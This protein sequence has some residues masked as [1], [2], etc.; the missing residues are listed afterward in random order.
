MQ[1]FLSKINLDFENL[2]RYASFYPDNFSKKE[3]LYLDNKFTVL[4][5]NKNIKNVN[6]FLKREDRSITNS[7]KNRGVSYQLSCAKKEG[8]DKFVLSTSGNAGITACQFLEKHGG[9]IIVVT[10][11][12][13]PKRKI[14]KLK[15]L[16]KNLILS[17]NPPHTANYI[18]KKYYYKNIR[19]S[20]DKNSIPGY[21]SLGF[22]IFEQLN[23]VPNNI[24]TYVTSGSSFIG[25]YKSFQIL[26]DLKCI[27]KIPA[28]Y[29]VR[30]IGIKTYRDKE[31]Q[32][33]CDKTG[34][35]IIGIS[36]EEHDSEIFKTSF[37]GRSTLQAVR[38]TKPMGLTVAI[39][40][41]SKYPRKEANLDKI[42][43]V[44]TIE[45]ID[46]YFKN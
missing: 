3:M 13:I 27:T 2:W 26:K 29:A 11:K 41:G 45:E 39:L 35:Q 21:Y 10:S 40:T 17:N 23:S 19:P 22:E 30:K 20:R 32:E 31:V 25:I 8:F 18:S 24:F 9:E 15:E 34:G 5:K 42:H 14:I 46:N 16:C 44:S 1:E 7:L 6:L 28:L 33:I 38:K 36:T 37:E 4:E 12:N 43:Q